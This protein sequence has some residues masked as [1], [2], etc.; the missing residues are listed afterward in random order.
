M[1]IRVIIN[2]R[3]NAGNGR[4][5]ENM[6]REKF[7]RSLV[8]IE[9]T[10][11]PRHA[12]RIAQRA[13]EDGVDTIVAA[14]GDGIINEVLNAI[15]GT[16]VALGII[17]TGTAND[18]ASYYH[19][20]K[21]ANNACDLI[22]RRRTERADVIR[23]NGWH[24]VTGGGV[25]L[26]SQAAEI[27]NAI[28]NRGAVGRL[29]ARLL[30]SKLYALALGCALLSKRAR[31]NPLSIRINGSSVRVNALSLMIDN[32]P[33]VGRDFLISPGA[34][35]DDGILDACLIENS[36][37]LLQ[38]MSTILKVLK[39]RHVFSSSVKTWRVKEMTVISREPTAFYGDGEINQISSEFRIK[40]LPGA[41]KV[42]TGRAPKQRLDYADNVSLTKRMLCQAE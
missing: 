18:L 15:V 28:K 29:C 10:A 41:L 8:S 1:K 26:P 9:Q 37:N 17:P 33:F 25:G 13:I 12:T 39:G 2:P 3:S 42:I 11:Y 40:L 34:V 27:A 31:L 16:D 38:T 4:C 5:F 6:V 21:D 32:Q 7:A 30:G 22:L 23:V 35:N 24:Y 19:I 14:G 20:S 36:K